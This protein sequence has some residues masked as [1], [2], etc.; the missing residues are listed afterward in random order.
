MP[1]PHLFYVPLHRHEQQITIELPFDGR[2]HFIGTHIHLF[3]ESIELFNVSRQERVWKRT[4]KPDRVGSAHME[5]YS[6][7]Q[8]YPVRAAETHRL[9]SIYDNPTSHDVD[10][11]TGI[12]MFYSLD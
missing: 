3:G 7:A 8:G 4:M 2:I 5:V 1:I 9:T 11:V 6:S 12:F 10:G